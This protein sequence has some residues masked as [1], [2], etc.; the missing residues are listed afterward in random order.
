MTGGAFTFTYSTASGGALEDQIQR[1]EKSH[2][3][4]GLIK[5]F[6]CVGTVGTE[7]RD[8]V[9]GTTYKAQIL[10]TQIKT[11]R[12]YHLENS[13]IFIHDTFTC[14]SN[15]RLGFLRLARTQNTRLRSVYELR[16]THKTHII[17][18]KA[19]KNIEKTTIVRKHSSATHYHFHVIFN[20][21]FRLFM[22]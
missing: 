18:E 19:K 21:H 9:G 11:V 10:E 20:L 3:P 2:T 14:N 4:A 13:F 16:V 1:Q 22:V 15:F 8:A 5:Q 7:Y 12:Q 6:I 17:T